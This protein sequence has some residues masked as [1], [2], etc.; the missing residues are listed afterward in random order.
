[1][2]ARTILRQRTASIASKAA[3]STSVARNAGSL[4][5]SHEKVATTSVTVH[6]PTISRTLN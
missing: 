6:F 4:P 1:M 2:L 5:A 3:F